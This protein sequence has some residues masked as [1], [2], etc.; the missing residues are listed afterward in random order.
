[1]ENI[2][3]LS[4]LKEKEKSVIF[5]VEE[6]NQKM[7][8]RL[9]ELGFVK[10]EKVEVIKNLKRGKNMLIAIRGYVLSL[11]YFIASKIMVYKK[12]E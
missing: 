2:V 6:I 1:M 10:N 5:L 7:N 8:R 4:S 9:I 3:K 12:G 11:D